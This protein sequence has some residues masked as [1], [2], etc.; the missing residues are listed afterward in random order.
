M[1]AGAR[2][3]LAS[4]FLAHSVPRTRA[5]ELSNWL[6]R[7]GLALPPGRSFGMQVAICM[8]PPPRFPKAHQRLKLYWPWQ[9][10]R[11]LSAL[12]NVC[13]STILLPPLPAPFL[14][15]SSACFLLHRH[16]CLPPLASPTFA[17]TTLERSLSLS[18]T[19]PVRCFVLCVRF[20]LRRA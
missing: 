10:S 9:N 11:A 15:A 12:S 4:C 7:I 19:L 6:A 16:P 8:R 20:D 3:R 5:R 2:A 13:L 14:S 1:L 17:Q 18:L